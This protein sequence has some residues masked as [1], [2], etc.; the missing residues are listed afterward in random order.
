MLPLS[1]EDK[2][3]IN[4]LNR[5]PDIKDRVKSIVSIANNDGDGIVTADEAES[6]VIEEVRR[7]GNEVLTGWA[8]SRVEKAGETLPSEEKT[9]RSGK[10]NLLA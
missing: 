8:E 10:K 1:Q 9:V 3:L 2:E 6:R 7:M 4:Q 5:H